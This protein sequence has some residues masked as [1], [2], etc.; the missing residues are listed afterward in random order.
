MATVVGKVGIVMRGDWNNSS[1]Y[2]VL[3][4][5][6]YSSALYIAKQAVPANTVPTNTTYWQLAADAA[7][8][9]DKVSGAT[10]NDLAMLNSSGNLVDAEIPYTSVK[11]VNATFTSV[12]SSN[13]IKIQ[14]SSGLNFFLVLVKGNT[15]TIYAV[16]LV[17]GYSGGSTRNNI[18]EV[19]KGSNIGTI[20]YETT[21]SSDY[22]VVVNF[23]GTAFS[24]KTVYVTA[25]PFYPKT[26]EIT[27]V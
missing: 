2:E 26:F 14:T 1:T 19:E 20:E 11:R 13:K 5:V 16:F 18:I 8:K 12:S 22:T 23:T 21:G 27:L 24:D 15:S 9:A 7:N 4:A 3:D 10:T 6:T 25:V 17:A